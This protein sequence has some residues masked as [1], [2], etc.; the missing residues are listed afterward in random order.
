MK[1]QVRLNGRSVI[2]RGPGV[3]LRFDLRSVVICSLMAGLTVLI[4]LWALASGDYPL[5]IPEVLA[6]LFNDPDAGFSRVV[7][8]EWRMPRVLAAVVFGAA[9]GA[10]GAIFQS[11]TRNPLA[12]PDVIGFS[13]G[14]YTGAL[15][16]IILIGGGYL[17][18]AAGALTGG[19]ATAAAVYLLAWR[20]GVQGFRLIIVGIGMS[21]MLA[22]FNTWLILTA[23]LDVAMSASAWGA[24]SLNATTWQQF[25]LGAVLISVIFLLLVGLAP[26]QRQLEMGDD[27]ARAT[28]VRG[29][30]ARLSLVVLG[31]AL[32]ATVTAAA[33]PI[34]FVALA[35]P[36]IARRLVRTPGVSLVPATVTGA[37]G[38]AAA[39]YTAHHLLPQSVPVGV[40]TVV[41][42]GAYLVWLLIREMR[43]RL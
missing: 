35:A 36:Q 21:A 15:V 3:A 34:A 30:R 14:A 11:L 24:G 17:H 25:S 13:T 37:L 6:A 38:L 10:S 19:V 33:G 31:V 28:G 16:V 5:S 12:S 27:A 23:D 39:D 1:A 32:T 26:S 22:S 29:E 42:G 40:V 2:L 20:R 7:V 8:L 9:L 4:S 43:R 18:L 41:L